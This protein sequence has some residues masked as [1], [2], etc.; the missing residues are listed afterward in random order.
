MNKE[1]RNAILR[2]KIAYAR[3]VYETKHKDDEARNLDFYRGRQWQEGEWPEMEQPVVNICLPVVRTIIPS[4]F[5]QNP[6]IYCTPQAPQY[7]TGAKILGAAL[8]CEFDALSGKKKV[9]SSLRDSLISRF[10]CLKVGWVHREKEVPITDE[11]FTEQFDTLILE[12]VMAAATG[13]VNAPDPNEIAEAIPKTK[14]QVIKDEP[15]MKRVSPKNIAIDPGCTDLDLLEEQDGYVVEWYPLALSVIKTDTRFKESVV[16]RLKGDQVEGYDEFRKAVETFEDAK[17]QTL[18]EITYYEGGKVKCKIFAHG[19]DEPLYENGD[20]EIFPYEFLL[21]IEIPDEPAGMP[22]VEMLVDHQRQLNRLRSIQFSHTLKALRKYL[23]EEGVAQ[24]MDAFKTQL[25]TPVDGGFVTVTNINGVQALPDIPLPQDVFRLLGDIMH[26][27]EF[28][29]QL[30][31]YAMGGQPD[32]KRLA[33]EVQ[34]TTM[35]AGAIMSDRL[36]MVT[37]FVE[38]VVTKLMK[39]MQKYMTEDKWADLTGEDVSQIRPFLGYYENPGDEASFKWNTDARIVT[40]P[41]P[42][43]VSTDGQE[44]SALRYGRKD[45]QGDYRV[46]ISIGSTIRQDDN[47]MRQQALDLFNL[48][49]GSN[50][51]PMINIVKLFSDLLE[52]FGK[53]NPQEYISQAPPMMPPQPGMEPPPGEGA[54]PALD[55]FT[56]SSAALPHLMGRSYDTDDMLRGPKQLA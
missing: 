28:M 12:S 3:S 32:F 6:K 31:R 55:Q 46:K 22:E 19:E 50:A 45:I 47:V 29:T 5:Y 48:A 25:K 53:T 14:P 56:R 38:R 54:P 18:E 30:S 36:M 33:T 13:S 37:D 34:A 39:F 40:N 41:N 20:L 11:E 43:A 7:A 42:M 16:K 27:V 24:D 23:V 1:E 9:R 26:D 35:G 44:I 15:F 8:N 4:T 2:A 21:N 10:G 17:V 51:A 52:A 49:A